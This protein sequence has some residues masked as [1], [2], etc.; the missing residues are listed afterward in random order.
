MARF[1]G[2]FE[3]EALFDHPVQRLSKNRLAAYLDHLTP[4]VG[5]VGRHMYLARLRD[6]FR[7]MFP[8]EVPQNLS[9]LVA[10]LARERQPRSKASRLVTTARLV[11]LGEILMREA[12][13]PRGAITDAIAYRDGLMIALLGA[14]P[15]RRRTLS[16][17]RIGTHLIRIGE[18]WRM[19]FGGPDTKSGQSFE[20]TIPA[21][22]VPSLERYLSE[23]RPLIA[24]ADR[25]N[26]LWPG[27]RGSPITGPGIY[28]VVTRRT[29]SAF[30]QPISPHLFRH[31][32]TTTIAII[33]P[34]RLGVARDLL[35][36]ASLVTTSSYY[37]KASSIEASRLYTKILAGLQPK[38]PQRSRAVRTSP[39]STRLARLA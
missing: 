18:E 7:A 22:L 26:G 32:A 39:T 34:G 33:Q 29:R 37:N 2:P 9:R 10:R 31:C 3:P 8:G 14:R 19:V 20:M 12:A 5:T 4:S 30:G 17:M 24:G 27:T 25:H 23:V 11:G 35:G 28:Q 6:A 16:L 13:G 1:P 15:V 38:G 21:R 36:H